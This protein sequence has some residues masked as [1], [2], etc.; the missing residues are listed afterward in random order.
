MLSARHC[1]KSLH[2]ISFYQ[3]DHSIRAILI[4]LVLFS[5]TWK[6]GIG[7]CG[8]LQ[9]HSKDK[10][11]LWQDYNLKY[12]TQYVIFNAPLKSRMV[13][14]TCLGG[15]SL[16]QLSKNIIIAFYL[17]SGTLCAECREGKATVWIRSKL[18][19]EP[20]QKM[21][22]LVISGNFEQSQ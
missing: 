11:H 9:A 1:T 19:V 18:Q 6:P 4:L 14:D 2:F 5:V 12:T 20:F 7:L 16:Q 8:H 13:S 3:N 15:L 21:C 17:F 10:L 22:F